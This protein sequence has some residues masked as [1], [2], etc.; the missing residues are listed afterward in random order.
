MRRVVQ[1]HLRG[2]FYALQGVPL[3]PA[4][5]VEVMPWTWLRGAPPEDREHWDRARARAT[6]GQSRTIG[7]RVFYFQ[8]NAAH[9]RNHLFFVRVVYFEN[10]E[11]LAQLVDLARARPI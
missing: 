1:K 8:F 4:Y 3:G 5:R 6:E 7:P 9:A 10:F 2:L 11:Y